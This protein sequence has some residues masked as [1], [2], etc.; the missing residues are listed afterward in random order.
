MRGIDAGD[1]HA[2]LLQHTA[3]PAFTTTDVERVQ[4]SAGQGAREHDGIEHIA[5]TE[6]AVFAHVGDPGV[7]RG[8]P[9]V[10]SVEHVVEAEAGRN[11]TS[12]RLSR[13]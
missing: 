9:A 2:V 7:G 1:L 6:I 5:P 13:L 10:I 4:G 8:F 11:K 12:P 3:E